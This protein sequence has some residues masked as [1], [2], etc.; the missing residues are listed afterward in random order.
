MSVSSVPPVIP[1]VLQP[2]VMI[3][4]KPIAEHIPSPLPNTAHYL[5][6]CGPPRSGKTSALISMLTQKNPQLYRRAFHNIMVVMPASSRHS[7]KND[8]FASLDDDK[9]FTDLTPSTLEAVAKKAEEEM[10]NNRCSLLFVDDM[11]SALKNADCLKA[12]NKLINNRRHLRL[13]IWCIVQTYKSVPLSNRRTITH[14]FMFKPNNRLEGEAVTSELIMMPPQEW[15]AYVQ[16]AFASGEPHAF[17]FLDVEHQAVYDK[18]FARLS[19]N[20]GHG[21]YRILDPV[22]APVE[23]NLS[24]DSKKRKQ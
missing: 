17:L 1:I 18:S 15:D 9:I 24:S 19:Y 6:S 21:Q 4:D 10:Q 8:P 16:H 23:Q 14:L 3:C 2:P 13:S 12:W 5:V 11:A 22:E 20:G 7:L